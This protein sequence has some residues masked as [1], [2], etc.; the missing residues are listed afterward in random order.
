MPQIHKAGHKHQTAGGHQLY[1]PPLR[2]QAYPP[3]LPGAWGGVMEKNEALK[4]FLKANR[5]RAIQIL[6]EKLF[7]RADTTEKSKSQDLG[8]ITLYFIGIMK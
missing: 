4:T 3:F 7:Q 5:V 1:K 6:W 8:L 2:K